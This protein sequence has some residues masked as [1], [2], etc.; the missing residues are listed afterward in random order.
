MSWWLISLLNT[1]KL[2]HQ[3]PTFDRDGVLQTVIETPKGSRNKF[4]F[5]P[6]SGLF[7]LGGAMPAGVIF[8]FDFGFVPSTLGEDGD[9]LDVLLLMD[10]PA[11]TGCL[12][13]ARLVGV[14]EA[15]QTERDGSTVRND[16]LIAVAE[17]SRVQGEVQSV[18]HLNSARLDEI[19]YFFQSYNTFKGKTFEVLAR[20]DGERALQLVHAGQAL[21]NKKSSTRKTTLRKKKA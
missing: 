16:R 17:H 14:I 15:N 4:D 20:S 3:L 5:E 12:V 7:K 10:A 13:G 6:E 9:P 1:R 18:E 2:P 8:P 11:F 21:Y 19:E